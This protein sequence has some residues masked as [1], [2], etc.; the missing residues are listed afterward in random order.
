M[1][2]LCLDWDKSPYGYTGCKNIANGS[3]ITSIP[4]TFNYQ[5]TTTSKIEITT[6]SILEVASHSQNIEFMLMTSQMVKPS[7]DKAASLSHG[8]LDTTNPVCEW[9]LSFDAYPIPN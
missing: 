8:F 7:T 6:G 9:I 1:H 5:Q 3:I 2:L 4:F